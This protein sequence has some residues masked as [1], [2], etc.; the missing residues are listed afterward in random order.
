MSLLLGTNNGSNSDP[1]FKNTTLLLKAPGANGAQN[2]T[3]IDSSSNAFTVTRNGGNPGM[4]QGSFSPFSPKGWSAHFNGSS[5]SLGFASAANLQ[6]GGGDF[7][8]EFWATPDSL[9]SQVVIGKCA[10]TN[11]TSEWVVV[12]NSDGSIYAEGLNSSSTVGACTSVAG[13]IVAGVQ[14]HIVWVRSGSNFGLFVNGARVAIASS[15]TAF[16]SNASGL[17]IGYGNG[18]SAGYWPGVISNVRLI[19]GTALYDPTQTTLTVPTSPLTAVSGTQLLCLQ[20]NRFKD[21][22]ANAY[23]AILAGTPTIQ[24]VSPFA[25]SVPYSAV[26]H[27]GGAYFDNTGDYLTWAANA[28]FNFGSGDLTV[29]VWA[30]PTVARDN[31]FIYGDCDSS[32]NNGSLLVTCDVNNKVVVGW[33]TSTTALSS[34]ASTVAVQTNAWNHIVV[35]KTG[36]NWYVGINGIMQT[37]AGPASILSGTAPACGNFGAV[38]SANRTFAGYLAG[39]R[40]LKGTALQTANYAV[41]TAPPTAITNTSLLLNFTNSGII[42][43]ASGC[44]L[45]TLGNAQCSTGIKKF[46]ES[47]VFDGTGDY[48]LSPSSS[49]WAIGTGDFT[50]EFWLFGVG[51]QAN[52]T[53]YLTTGLSVGDLVIDQQSTANRITINDNNT[54]ILSTLSAYTAATWTHVAFCRSGTSLKVFLDGVVSNSTTNSTNFTQAGLSIGAAIDGS[55]CFNGQMEDLRIT[56]YARYTGAFTPPATQFPTN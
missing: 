44:A 46:V 4:S 7:T 10:S 21:N 16:N 19:K 17:Y 47:V 27:G 6:V 31:N 15:A 54:V 11:A 35:S 38:V 30:Y 33:Y 20:S 24:A 41:P 26:N 9:V 12:T 34:S 45:E 32:T 53:K 51:S 49:R 13:V 28:A 37:I 42:D 3:F 5:D 22:S 2:N 1:Y 23:A 25:P 40:I 48:L 36:S 39:F 52:F 43:A 55:S 56:N 50:I 8:I 29:E 14:H 18:F